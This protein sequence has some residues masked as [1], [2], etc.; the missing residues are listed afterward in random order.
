[1]TYRDDLNLLGITEDDCH[2]FDDVP[3]MTT[4]K[5]KFRALAHRHHPDLGGDVVAFQ[6]CREAYRRV[7]AEV[8]AYEGKCTECN[9]AGVVYI[10]STR[11][12]AV[13]KQACPRGCKPA[14]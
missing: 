4:L 2:N 14:K 6:R 11:S 7:L 3:S 12:F 1:M 10:H 9:G 8:V 13:L 5:E